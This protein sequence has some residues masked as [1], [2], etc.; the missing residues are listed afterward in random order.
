VPRLLSLS[1]LPKSNALLSHKGN[2]SH[3]YTRNHQVNAPLKGLARVRPDHRSDAP[4]H[5]NRKRFDSGTNG[6]APQPGQQREISP[7]CVVSLKRA[8]VT[9]SRPG[10]PHP[11]PCMPGH[12]TAEVARLKTASCVIHLNAPARRINASAKSETTA[13]MRLH[14]AQSWQ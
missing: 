4:G 9:M 3:S 12:A 10:M 14:S 13:H 7:W 6:N 8:Y 2:R 1:A 5:K 11:E